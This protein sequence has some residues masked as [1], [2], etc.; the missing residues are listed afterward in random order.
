M[1][2]FATLLAHLFVVAAWLLVACAAGLIALEESGMLT[3]IV[4]ERIAGELGELGEHV[5]VERARLIWFEPGLSLEGITF[6]G[7]RS[8]DGSWVDGAE[9]VR[10]SE[11]HV[12]LHPRF[13]PARPV[14]EVEIRGGRVVLARPLLDAVRALAQR[15]PPAEPGGPARELPRIAVRGLALELELPGGTPLSLGRADLA[16]DPGAAGGTALRGR[17]SP[18]LGGAVLTPADIRLEGEAA[19]D[20][21]L[22]LHAAVRGLEIDS[23]GLGAGEAE[24][25]FD[26]ERLRGELAFDLFVRA[27]PGALAPDVELHLALEEG[28]VARRAGPPVEELDLALSAGW[29]AAAGQSFLD[30]EAWAVT[31]R[32]GGLCGRSRIEAGARVGRDAGQGS[33]LEGWLRA[34]DLPLDGETLRALQLEEDP[35]VLEA[36]AALEPRGTADVTA[37]FRVARALPGAEGPAPLALAVDVRLDGAAAMTY[38]GWKDEH[39]VRQ[40]VPLPC[41]NVR[42]RVAVAWQ[43][44][45]AQPALIGLIGLSGEHGSGPVLADGMLSSAREGGRHADFDLSLSI[46]RIAVDPRLGAGLAGLRKIGPLWESLSPVGGELSSEWHLRARGALGGL[47]AIGLVELHGVGIEWSGLPV[48]VA[49]VEGTIEMR[50]AAQVSRVTDAP[51]TPYG[52]VPAYRPLAVLWR[53]QTAPGEGLSVRACGGLHQDPLPREVHHADIPLTSTD[54][55]ELDLTDLFLRGR[56]WDALAASLPEM[57]ARVQDLRAQGKVDASFRGRRAAPGA[58]YPYDLEVTAGESAVVLTP[59]FFRR[60]TQDVTGRVLIKGVVDPSAVRSPVDTRF[61]LFGAWGGDVTLASTGALA[62]G[63]GGTIAVFGAGVDPSSPTLKGALSTTLSKEPRAG[64]SVDLST[65]EVDGRLDFEALITLPLDPAQEPD[66]TYRVFLRENRLRSERFGLESLHGVF[67]QEDEVLRSPVLHASLAGT[68]IE[69]RNVLLLPLRSAGSVEGADPRLLDPDFLGRRGGYGLQAD[70]SAPGLVLDHAHLAPFVDEG[71]LA[72]L[73]AHTGLSGSVDVSGAH[74]LAVIDLDGR[75]KVTFQGHVAPH[76]VR[77]KAAVPLSLERGAIEVEDLVLEGGRVR[78]WWR[79]D[80]L[81]AAVAEREIRDA[82]MIMTFVDGR[83][84]I[85]NLR[86]SFGGGEVSSLGGVEQADRAIAVDLT[87]PYAY[88]L[89]LRLENVAVDAFMGGLFE[90]SVDDLGTL[91]T[92]LRLRGRGGDVL[93][94]GGGGTVHLSNAR[95][96][97]IPVVRELFRTLGAD[98]TAVFDRMELSWSLADG[99]LR[100]TDM[101]VRSP[102]LSLVG[103]GSVEL[104]GEVQGDLQVR[105]ALVDRLGP[106]NRVVYWLN[107]SLWQ[108]AVRGEVGRP[109]VKIRNSLFDLVFGFDDEGPRSLPLPG[110]SPLSTRF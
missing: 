67:V 58:P 6:D 50:W 41:S 29:K 47:T 34:P 75:E 77:L 68:P 21:G 87:P 106:L 4:E 64:E 46:P 32:A 55:L 3:R 90:S 79:I 38:H 45:L 54:W 31:A 10:L 40:G 59:S 12:R 71:T 96:W 25:L 101:R 48:P 104:T 99:T 8:P 51:L 1:K 18:S 100:L 70:W 39:G 2:R 108:V 16:A 42:G 36:Y 91:S 14:E 9:R 74:V 110:W 35:A 7:E 65:L 107:N 53:M 83:L 103:E 85:D 69:L 98:A 72:L 44:G 22:D 80:D 5:R 15:A 86:G 37:G 62:Q 20:G 13:D 23:F 97:S 63:G 102:L 24:H 49:G 76:D 30:P 73:L 105:Y 81:T 60:Q 57:G 78:G 11:V 109:R 66:S 43:D 82:S 17:I 93:A 89:A 88:A 28:S 94:L 61:A 56:A 27:A 26:V 95:L 52:D 33:M 19:A 92:A 84:T